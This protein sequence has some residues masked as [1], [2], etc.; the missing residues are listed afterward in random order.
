MKVTR[1]IIFLISFSILGIRADLIEN[2]DLKRTYLTNCYSYKIS[3]KTVNFCVPKFMQKQ[4]EKENKSLIDVLQCLNKTPNFFKEILQKQGHFSAQG[5]EISTII[6][7]SKGYKHPTI[8]FNTTPVSEP[9]TGGDS[10]I[11]FP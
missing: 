5:D 9:L 10:I 8:L 1:L 4:L 7:F 3:S 6:S 2:G 11:T